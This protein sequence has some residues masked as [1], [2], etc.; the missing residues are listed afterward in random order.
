MF[1]PECGKSLTQPAAAPRA[2]EKS[3]PAETKVVDVD[4]ASASAKVGI[5]SAATQDYAQAQAQQLRVGSA[6]ESA[7]ES[8]SVSPQPSK[9]G[10]IEKARESLH[11]ASS[12][13]REALADNVKRVDRIRQVSS[14]MIEE[15][16]Y[17]PSLR[18]VLVALA[19]FV[20]F[21]ILLVLSKVMG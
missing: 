20:V 6:S 7:K 4:E 5:S 1:C 16:A 9:T 13:S 21:V 15:A 8:D 19:V 18:F 14:T 12:A 3:A 10:T 11:R 2:D 17:D